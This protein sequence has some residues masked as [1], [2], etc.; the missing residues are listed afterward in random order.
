MEVHHCFLYQY[1]DELPLTCDPFLLLSSCCTL[2]KTSIKTYCST[3]SPFAA[4]EPLQIGL[5]RRE[6]LE[7]KG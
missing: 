3:Y 2:L 5:T 7:D 4:F 6:I 1:Y